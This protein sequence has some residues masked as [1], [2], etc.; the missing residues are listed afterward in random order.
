MRDFFREISQRRTTP[1]IRA[2]RSRPEVFR[3]IRRFW[4]DERTETLSG[5]WG[6]IT[7]GISDIVKTAAPMFINME[8]QKAQIKQQAKV[9]QVAGSQLYTPE[10][11]AALQRQ[12][13][14]ETAERSVNFARSQNEIIP[15]VSPW[16]LAAGLG[17]GL[18]LVLVMNRKK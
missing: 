9:I 18:V 15:G 12:Q 8:L 10:N 4:R 13:Q 17:A 14:Y 16:M 1:K 5:I 3:H 7:G 6:D 2:V 11:I